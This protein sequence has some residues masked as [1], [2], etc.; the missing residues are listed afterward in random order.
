MVIAI[1]GYSSCGKSTLAKELAT[2]LQY[3]YIDS[4]A[5]YRAVTYYMMSEDLAIDEDDVCPRV[6]D[7]EIEFRYNGENYQNEIWLNGKN[8]EKE[9]RTLQVANNVSE[10][11]A[12]KCV[13]D[14]LVDLQKSF[15]IKNDIVMD[16]R[17]IGTVIF[18]DAEVKLFV[19]ADFDTRVERRYQELQRRGDQVTREDVAQNLQKR[20]YIDTHREVAPLSKADDAVVLDNTLLDKE[21]QLNEALSIV[22]EKKK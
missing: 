6:R 10:I 19:Q 22:Y 14:Y 1:D 18:P 11:A 2:S 5:M 4:G 8:V 3:I 20:D 7:V 13:R 9:I 21:Q 16:G 15:A 17:D 12:M